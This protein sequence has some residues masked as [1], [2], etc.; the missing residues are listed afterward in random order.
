MAFHCSV[1]KRVTLTGAVT[2][3]VLPVKKAELG[4]DW[5]KLHS[6]SLKGT[7]ADDT[8][9]GLAASRSKIQQW[10]LQCC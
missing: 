3:L 5:Y 4:N 1:A 8:S 6:G 2:H 7:Q 9:R 10:G